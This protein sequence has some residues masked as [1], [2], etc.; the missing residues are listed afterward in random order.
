MTQL[1]KKKAKDKSSLS[2][3]RGDTW[4]EIAGEECAA[5]EDLSEPS[6]R[7]QRSGLRSLG[8]P[9]GDNQDTDDAHLRIA[10][11]HLGGG[12]TSC[13]VCDILHILV[14][15]FH[16]K[17]WALKNWQ[18]RRIPMRGSGA[19]DMAEYAAYACRCD[20][21]SFEDQPAIAGKLVADAKRREN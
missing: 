6:G 14:R 19:R 10:H 16:D 3:G 9:A 7:P 1:L 12:H 17:A 13:V 5:D 18:A 11:I 2:M 8:H 15:V 21:K 20:L 4:V